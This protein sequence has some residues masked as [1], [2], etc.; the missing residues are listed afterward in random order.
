MNSLVIPAALSSGTSWSVKN[1]NCER[2]KIE[3]DF[4]I[5]A[6]KSAINAIFIYD[7]NVVKYL[8]LYYIGHVIILGI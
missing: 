3:S 4:L 1:F 7:I 6:C 2:W 8:R 5:P